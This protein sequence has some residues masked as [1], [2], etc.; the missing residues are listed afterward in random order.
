[1]LEGDVEVRARAT[2]VEEML[3]HI[4]DEEEIPYFVSDEATLF[5]VCSLTPEEIAERLAAHYGRRVQITELRLPIWRLVD[6][7]RAMS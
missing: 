4:C 1:M 7:L 5:D 6:R 2:Q 3:R